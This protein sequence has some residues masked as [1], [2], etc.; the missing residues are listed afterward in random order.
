MYCLIKRTFILVIS[1]N[2]DNSL[3]HICILV[4]A[5]FIEALSKDWLVVVDVADENPH[6]GCVCKNDRMADDSP[7]QH[8]NTNTF[9]LTVGCA[10][11]PSICLLI[12]QF[13]VIV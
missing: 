8:T 9:T 6:I 12:Q 13:I 5:N 2:S 7:T 1:T 3:A 11:S 10:Y 4:D